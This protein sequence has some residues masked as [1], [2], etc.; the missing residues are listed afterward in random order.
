MAKK[1]TKNTSV[2][3]VEQT[4]EVKSDL[5]AL[6]LPVEQPVAEV[7]QVEEI[8]KVKNEGVGKMVRELIQDGLT[9]TEILKRVHSEYGNTNTTYAC[10]AWY[11]N[12]VKK[13]TE[14]KT[15]SKAVETVERFLQDETETVLDDGEIEVETLS[16]DLLQ[17]V[18]Q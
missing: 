8:K 14:M 4:Q 9:N 11:R 13:S 15:V 10:V 12:K 18:G 6:L 2:E 1:S 5:I 17:A 16:D 3:I 7:E